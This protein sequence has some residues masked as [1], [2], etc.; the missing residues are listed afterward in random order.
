[1][2]S[3][4][5]GPRHSAGIYNNTNENRYEIITDGHVSF[6]AYRLQGNQLSIDHVF[7]PEELRGQGM[8]AK[9]M[10]GV[11]ADAKQRGLT[12]VPV[13]SYAQAYMQRQK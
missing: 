9:I 7:V 6:A 8:A 5:T 12:I 3:T 13:C 2:D 4:A 10:E 11:V 1:M